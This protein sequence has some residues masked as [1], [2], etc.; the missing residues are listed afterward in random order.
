M[1]VRLQ[2]QLLLVLLLLLV[3]AVVLV[4]SGCDFFMHFSSDS[5][6]N[7]VLSDNLNL[8]LF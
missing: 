7:L 2:L 4:F 6:G 1:V 5:T 3:M 8:E